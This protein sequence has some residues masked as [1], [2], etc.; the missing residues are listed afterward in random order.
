MSPAAHP[1]ARIVVVDDEQT[2]LDL[3]GRILARQGYGH[4]VLTTDARWVL[5]NLDALAPDLMLL[6]L[7]M[8]DVDGFEM[9]RRLG[10]AVPADDFLPQLVITADS[11]PGT[12]RSALA[13]GAHD[14]LNKPID[15]TETTLR[16]ANL[17]VTRMLHV[18]VQEQNRHL[19]EQVDARTRQLQV[20]HTGLV[21]RLALVAEY[22]DDVTSEHAVRVGVAA[23]RLAT[24]VGLPSALAR[25]IG[26]A[27]PLHDIGKVGIPDSILLKPGPLTTQE[28][29][30]MKGHAAAG[31]HILG[32]GESELLRLGE[33]VALTHH[34]RWDGTGYPRGQVGDT[35]PLSGRLVAIVD[36]FDALTSRRPYKPA[37]SVDRAAAHMLAQRA[38][39]FDPEFLD[40]FLGRLGSEDQAPAPGPVATSPAVPVAAAAGSATE[41][42]DPIPRRLY[43]SR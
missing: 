17:L 8:P 27:A 37:W 9:L 35:I 5:K 36:V 32:G 42:V 29:E 31:A 25:L 39:H 43:T 7:H 10:A 41:N 6:D 20:A 3:I 26:E 21:H 33:Q 24:A 12:R 38:L 13:L 18:R 2:N 34:E 15:V 30:T 4:V 22:R 40:V 16:V 11:T 14:F 19:E 28:F 23:H 1:Q